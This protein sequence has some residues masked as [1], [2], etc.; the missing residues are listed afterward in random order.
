MTQKHDSGLFEYV[1]RSSNSSFAKQT[2]VAQTKLH[3]HVDVYIKD[4]LP[5][6]FDIERVLAKIEHTIPASLMEDKTDVPAALG[7]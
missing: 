6:G 3:G 2:K 5:K 4:S 1:K 7:R